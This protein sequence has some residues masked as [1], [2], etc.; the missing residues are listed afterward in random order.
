MPTN[1]LPQEIIPKDIESR[2]INRV[3]ECFQIAKKQTRT[4]FRFEGVK[5]FSRSSTAGYVIPVRDNV[6]YLNFELFKRN[7]KEFMSTIIPHEVAHIVADKLHPS[8]RRKPHSIA[9]KN[10]MREVFN[11]KP[12]RCHKLNTDGIGVKRKKFLYICSCAKH[13]IGETRHKKISQSGKKYVCNACKKEL[14]F[15]RTA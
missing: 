12:E 3:K 15:L 10:V 1:I 9:W 4:P 5:F 7:E 6:V 8:F 13:T 14:V 2:A 11:L